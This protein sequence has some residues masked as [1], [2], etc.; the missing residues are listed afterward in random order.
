MGKRERGERESERAR[1]TKNGFCGA[2]RFRYQ[3]G[4]NRKETGAG[5]GG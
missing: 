2:Q 4:T 3:L 1:G 5:E